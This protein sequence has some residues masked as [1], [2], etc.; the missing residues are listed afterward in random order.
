MVEQRHVEKLTELTEQTNKAF[1]FEIIAI[2]FMLNKNTAE[3]YFTEINLNPGWAQSDHD[4]TGVDVIG[5]TA[6]YFEE[7]CK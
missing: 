4:V 1:G 2:D 3:F 5:L 7:L 6:D